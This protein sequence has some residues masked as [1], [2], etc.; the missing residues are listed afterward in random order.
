MFFALFYVVLVIVRPHEYPAY[1][2]E[3]WPILP[4]ALILALIERAIGGR[5]RFDE[6]QYYLLAMFLVTMMLSVAV[7]GW[8]G[9]AIV[10]LTQ[11]GP[12]VAA[13]VLLSNAMTTPA[14]VRRAMAV[15]VLSAC[16]LAADG[17]HQVQTGFGW[18]G[19]PPQEDGRIQYIGIFSDPN[20]MGLI[21]AA[22][23]PFALHLG[24]RGGWLGLVRLF[25]YG[26]AALLLYG[27]YLTASR[28]AM[29]AVAMM[30]GVWVWRHRGAITAMVVAAGGMLAMSALPSRMQE[31]D[32]SESSAAGRIDAWYEGMQMFVSHP[33]LGVGP[34]NFTEYNYLT[35]HNSFVLVLAETG[36]IGFT[37][38]LAFVIYGFRMMYVFEKVQ[39]D[40]PDATLAAAWEEDRVVGRVLFLSLCGFF[41]AAFFLSRS[42]IP[43]LYFLAAVVVGEY[44]NARERFPSLPR[45]S[46][47]RDALRL[48]GWSVGAIVC[49]YLLVRVL[50]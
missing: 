33:L 10:Q 24:G 6:P 4:I 37:I 31:L 2:Q 18:T 21:F 28:G 39:P 50:L 23:L 12:A 8:P 43:V 17:V 7:N 32:A 9:G 22:F 40:L 48:L 3:Q 34:G 15:F 42:Y 11:F 49:L 44:T 46:L 1:V 47:E 25:W 26:A 16:V 45:F 5:W 13:F 19:V 30:L 14:R 29:L 35:A 27:I 38:W 36:F 41:T 20:D